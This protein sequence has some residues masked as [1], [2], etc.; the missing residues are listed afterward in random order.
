MRRL[1]VS[2]SRCNELE[3]LSQQF[4]RLILE[5]SGSRAGKLQFLGSH[6]HLT[7]AKTST[8]CLA[9]LSKKRWFAYGQ[10][11]VRSSESRPRLSVAVYLDVS[12]SND[13]SFSRT[14]ATA[15]QSA[16]LLFLLGNYRNARKFILI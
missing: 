1:G 15:Q 14:A 8:A 5:A 4:R 10:A 7:D 9:P 11:A 13:R 12:K 2:G 3:R 6:A 16:D